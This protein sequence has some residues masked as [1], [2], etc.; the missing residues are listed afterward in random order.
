[1]RWSCLRSKRPN[2]PA[3]RPGRGPMVSST[4]VCSWRAWRSASPLPR[5]PPASCSLAPRRLRRHRGSAADGVRD[6]GHLLGAL[7]QLGALQRDSTALQADSQI[8]L[9][10]AEP[11]LDVFNRA[12]QPLSLGLGAARRDL[13]LPRGRAGL[14]RLRLPG[15]RPARAPSRARAACLCCSRSRACF[16]CSR[17]RACFSRVAV[18]WLEA[19]VHPGLLACPGRPALAALRLAARSSRGAAVAR[20]PRARHR[21]RRPRT[22]RPHRHRR[23]VDP[24]AAR[25]ASCG[26]RRPRSPAPWRRSGGPAPPS[27][28]RRRRE[29]HRPPPAPGQPDVRG[30]RVRVA[31][32]AS[33][34]PV[35]CA[36]TAFARASKRRGHELRLAT[37]DLVERPGRSRRLARRGHERRPATSPAARRAARSR[38]AAARSR[39][40]APRRGRSRARRSLCAGSRGLAMGLR[41]HRPGVARDRGARASSARAPVRS[42]ARRPAAI[43][44]R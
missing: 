26:R 25:R 17:S 11:L 34:S 30:T 35:V 13:R 27:A 28:R 4:E 16:S 5:R 39:R 9:R 20:A 33:P 21:A 32:R 23:R 2:R 12:P 31:R 15:R 42:R 24:R 29:R 22:D 38:A 37:R 1:M 3:R 43:V 19:F 40:T 8:S 10:L 44:D 7:E 41:R 14:A 18:V 36:A 6:R